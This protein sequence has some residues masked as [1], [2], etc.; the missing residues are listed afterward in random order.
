[1]TDPAPAPLSHTEGEA[2]KASQLMVAAIARAKALGYRYLPA[3]EVARLPLGEVL[4]RIEL[5][6]ENGNQKIDRIAL[7]GGVSTRD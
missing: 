7:L 3:D 4:S 6:M 1:M 5:L 2:Q